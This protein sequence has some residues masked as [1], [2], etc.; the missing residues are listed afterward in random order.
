MQ[1]MVQPVRQTTSG[2]AVVTFGT[3]GSTVPT[4]L[5]HTT[6][7]QPFTRESIERLLH[8]EVPAVR[9]PEFATSA[10]TR[11]FSEAMLGGARR[12]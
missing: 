3:T 10:E 9:L 11:A 6:D 12:G 2:G 5:W 4:R 7:V 1:C 8:H